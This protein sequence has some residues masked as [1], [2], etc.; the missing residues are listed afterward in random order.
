REN[1]TKGTD[2]GTGGAMVVAGGALRG[3]RV[4]GDWPGLAD[5][6]LYEGRDLLPTAD[7][8][9]YAAWTMRGLFGIDRATLEG[10]I[11][12]RLDMGGDPG[13]VL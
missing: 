5:N 2:H 13:I 11:F 9:A 6:Q 7:V 12:P 10:R 8:R 1:G 3:G 4:H